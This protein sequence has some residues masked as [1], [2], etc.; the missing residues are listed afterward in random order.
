[1]DSN[2]VAMIVVLVVWLG[3]FIYIFKLD[4]KVNK[5]KDE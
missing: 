5:L 2:Y 1:M 3:I 4:K